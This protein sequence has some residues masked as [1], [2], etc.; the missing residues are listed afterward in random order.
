MKQSTINLEAA[1]L[2]LMPPAIKTFVDAAPEI[3]KSATAL[4]CLAPMGALACQLEAEYL[5]GELQ[6]PLFQ[7][8]VRAPQASGKGKMG[9]VV[10]RILRPLE[11]S[12]DE[13]IKLNHDYWDDWFEYKQ[14]NPKATVEQMLE[15]LGPEPIPII[16]D[17]GSKVSTTA[18]LEMSHKAQGLALILSNDEADSLVKSWSSN[19]TDISDMLRIG[20]DGGKYKQHMASVSKTFS[21]K[22]NLRI[23]TALCGTS[24]AYDRLFK[25]HV[26]GAV[27]RQLFV[28]FPNLMFE[29][30]LHWHKFTDAEE[31]ELDAMLQRLSDMSLKKMIDEHWEVQP[32]Y[33][34][35]L[36]YVNESM[37]VWLENE[38]IRSKAE[39]NVTRGTFYKR[40]AVMG[41]RA[42]ILA[43]FLWNE[44]EDATLREGVVQFARWVADMALLG[45]LKYYSLPEDAES[46]FVGRRIYDELDESFTTADVE[47]LTKF[48]EMRSRP[49]DIVDKWQRGKK[50]YFSGEKVMTPLGKRKLYRKVVKQEQEVEY[51][52]V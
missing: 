9:K 23:A 11:V 29:P 37:A 26:N 1:K 43:H 46:D 50:A 12:E 20:W 15:V 38:R 25:N 3:L 6:T 33:R 34:M 51:G 22:V 41:F 48:F 35:D 10:E 39:N 52:K 7:T 8:N 45:H 5:D 47:P 28:G 14:A 13:Q 18:M 19:N 4:T 16:R 24:D 17:L 40:A 21:G 49:A 31:A 44:P 30:M 27:G 36:G 2:P 42:A 32:R